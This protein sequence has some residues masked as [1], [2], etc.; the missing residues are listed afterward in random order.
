MSI[1]RDYFR[2]I[3]HEKVQLFEYKI[4]EEKDIP[5]RVEITLN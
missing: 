2:T 1:F 5:Q 4:K 3:T